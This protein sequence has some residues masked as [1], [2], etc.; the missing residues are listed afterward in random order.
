MN[1]KKAEGVNLTSAI[2]FS[3]NAS[4]GERMKP[5][6]LVPF[7]KIMSHIFPEILIKIPLVVQKI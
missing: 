4:S 1:P 6:F 5:C 3:K 7:N 2:G